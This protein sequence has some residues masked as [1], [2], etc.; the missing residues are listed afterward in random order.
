MCRDSIEIRHAA[1]LR[2]DVGKVAVVAP[3][4]GIGAVIAERIYS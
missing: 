1:E 2:F 3:V 4:G